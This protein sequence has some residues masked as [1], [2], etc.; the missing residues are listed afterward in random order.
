[1]AQAARRED[2]LQAVAQRDTVIKTSER[3]RQ[4]SEG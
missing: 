1:M 3:Y 2:S 4:I